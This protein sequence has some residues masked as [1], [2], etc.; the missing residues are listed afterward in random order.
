VTEVLITDR[1]TGNHSLGHR[2][3]LSGDLIE[4]VLGTGLWRLHRQG[5]DEQERKGK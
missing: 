3:T 2:V 5:S 1:N 4:E